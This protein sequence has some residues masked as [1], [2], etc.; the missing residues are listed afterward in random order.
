LRVLVNEFPIF[1]LHLL[2]VPVEHREHILSRDLASVVS[3][4]RRF[5]D[6]MVFHNMRGAGASRPE[7]L[8]FQSV[9]RNDQL[10]LL[11]APRRRLPVMSA[12]GTRFFA[13]DEYP[14]YALLVQGRDEVELT[15]AV[16]RSLGARPFNLLVTHDGIFIIPRTK[17]RAERFSTQFAALEM[18]GCLVFVDRQRFEDLPYEEAWGAVAE[19]GFDAREGA[20]LEATLLGSDF[21]R[22]RTT[23]QDLGIYPR[24]DSSCGAEQR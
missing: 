16:F 17:E 7:H 18:A 13:V 22:G 2:L 4:V 10:P 3:F 20:A 1:P 6:F 12:P 24:K 14:A 23:G 8:H 21:G 5:P 19:C 9:P 11:T 15:F